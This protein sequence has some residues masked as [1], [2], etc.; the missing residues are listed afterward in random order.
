MKRSLCVSM[1]LTLAAPAWFGAAP[2]ADTPT[3]ADKP[4]AEPDLHPKPVDPPPPK[5]LEEAIDRGIAFLLQDQN[6]DGSW[7]SPTRTKG[8][9]IYAPF[10][11]SHLAFRSAVTGL[12]ISALIETGGSSPAV[13]KAVERAEDWLMENLPQ[14]RRATDRKSVVEGQSVDR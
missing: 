13:I 9:N 14:L 1:L 10:Y 6:K 7:G 5:A 11:D 4:A 12:C 8:L 3:A 2:P